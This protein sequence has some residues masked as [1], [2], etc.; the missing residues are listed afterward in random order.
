MTSDSIIQ[1]INLQNQML[2]A[3]QT[4][5]C[6]DAS[7]KSVI[8]KIVFSIDID[9]MS[10]LIANEGKKPIAFIGN[11]DKDCRVNF[12][13]LGDLFVQLCKL[14][15]LQFDPKNKYTPQLFFQE[16]SKTFPSNIQSTKVSAPED[17][18]L[19]YHINNDIEEVDKIYF[20]KWLSHGKNGQRNVSKSNLEKTRK[21]FGDDTYQYCKANN[22]SSC[23]TA[24]RS[25]KQINTDLI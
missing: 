11:V 5:I 19:S 23:W 18:L 9:P 13:H 3:N 15:G 16:L 7:C 8:F 4:S 12:K 2:R 24:D 14:L 10:L 6:F 22:I 20:L 17:R 1:L 25:E 21:A